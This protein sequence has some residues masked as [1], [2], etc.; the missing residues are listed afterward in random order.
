MII[1]I[2]IPKTQNPSISFEMKEK[3]LCGGFGEFAIKKLDES[4]S[5]H[6]SSRRKDVKGQ[7]IGNRGL[8][9]EPSVQLKEWFI[10]PHYTPTLLLPESVRIVNLLADFLKSLQKHKTDKHVRLY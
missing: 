2:K 10:L 9:D 5:F 4:G 7:K 1:A 8:D 3:H 6:C